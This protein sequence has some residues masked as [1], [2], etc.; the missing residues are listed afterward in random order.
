MNISL[1]LLISFFATAAVLAGDIYSYDKPAT[2]TGT[3]SMLYDM[4]FVDSD[5]S[6]VKDPAGI[7]AKHPITDSSL[8]HKPVRHW[9]LTLE[10]PISVSPGKTDG[11]QNVSE[12][13]LGAGELKLKNGDHVT[14]TGKLWPAATVHHLRPV[15][16]T[17]SSIA[18]TPKRR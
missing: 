11:L 13:D 1:S 16:M 14:V 3:V 5:M 8:P 6:P 15:M 18:S 17:K 9:I 4:S 7:K 12:I 2:L 10:H